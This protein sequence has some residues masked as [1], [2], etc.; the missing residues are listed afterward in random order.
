MNQLQFVQQS[1]ADK[2][3]PKGKI[4]LGQQFPCVLGSMGVVVIHTVDRKGYDL[5]PGVPQPLLLGHQRFEFTD[6][7]GT[8]GGPK[9]QQNGLARQFTNG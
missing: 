4:Q 7:H 3:R 8:P 2:S 1:F 6:A 5:E 9:C